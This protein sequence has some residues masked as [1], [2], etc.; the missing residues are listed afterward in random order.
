M[1]QSLLVGL[2]ALIWAVGT[3]GAAASDR[4]GA[5]PDLRVAKGR[6][7]VAEA[8]LADPTRRYQHFVLGSDYEAGSLVVKLT[9]GRLLKLK[10]G[11]DAVFED[12]QPRL[13]D[14]DGDGIDEINLVKSYLA[15]GAALAF[16][17]TS[18]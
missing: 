8:W 12:R 17:A 16:A 10:L 2:L 4:P 9:N 1:R 18:W 5:L 6:G 14:L 7:L 11:E 13:A 15:R 3:A